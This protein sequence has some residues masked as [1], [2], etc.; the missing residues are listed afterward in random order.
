MTQEEI[1]AIPDEVWCEAHD[2]VWPHTRHWPIEDKVMDGRGSGMCSRITRL[3]M[4][5]R[6]LKAQLP[7]QVDPDLLAARKIAAD[8][9]RAAGERDFADQIEAGKHD[10][11]DSVQL[12]LRGIK[13]G[14]GEG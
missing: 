4:E 12:A 13:H 8:W 10:E 6:A 3:I 5:N 11:S 14:R 1:A 2:L 9:W 7:E